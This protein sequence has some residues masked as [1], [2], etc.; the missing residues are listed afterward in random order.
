MREKYY[1]L[2]WCILYTNTMISSGVL[3]KEGNKEDRTSRLIN[4]INIYHKSEKYFS[5]SLIGSLGSEVI[6]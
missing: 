6:S 4:Y 2:V 1:S 3:L 5:R